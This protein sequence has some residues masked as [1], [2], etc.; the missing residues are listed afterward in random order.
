MVLE[1]IELENAKN[2]ESLNG[3]FSFIGRKKGN[4][5]QV[6]GE[7]SAIDDIK[8]E[9]GFNDLMFMKPEQAVKSLNIMVSD[10]AY[11]EAKHKAAARRYK[12]SNSISQAN[13]IAALHSQ[14]SSEVISQLRQYALGLDGEIEKIG[15]S[16]KKVDGFEFSAPFYK[17]RLPVKAINTAPVDT[18]SKDD[19]LAILSKQPP[20][21][22]P[23]VPVE[24]KDNT[25]MIVGGSVLGLLVLGTTIYAIKSKKSK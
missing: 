4:S 14:A 2:Q 23:V 19:L 18:V 7:V 10:F 3:L 21:A 25:I 22:S 17:L 12:T 16:K 20:V 6:A 9:N 1:F 15:S 5:T 24:K 11:H 13:K 8:A